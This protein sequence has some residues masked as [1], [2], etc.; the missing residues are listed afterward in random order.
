MCLLLF[1]KSLCSVFNFSQFFV[2]L[3]RYI[4]QIG[5]SFCNLKM[6]S[7]KNDPNRPKS[8]TNGPSAD[9]K[10]RSQFYNYSSYPNYYSAQPPNREQNSNLN[11][12]LAYT[13]SFNEYLHAIGARTH[14]SQGYNPTQTTNRGIP[15]I[16]INSQD[17]RNQQSPETRQETSNAIINIHNS[18]TSYETGN[19]TVDHQ[20]RKEN[21]YLNETNQYLGRRSYNEPSDELPIRHRKKES[22]YM[23]EIKNSNQIPV[24]GNGLSSMSNQQPLFPNQPDFSSTSS[25]NVI[26]LNQQYFNNDATSNTSYDRAYLRSI[27]SNNDYNQQ[28]YYNNT[29]SSRQQIYPFSTPQN[30]ANNYEQQ[31]QTTSQSQNNANDDEDNES[32]YIIKLSNSN[33]EEENQAL[34]FSVEQNQPVSSKELQNSSNDK[35]QFKVPDL[36]SSDNNTKEEDEEEEYYYYDEEIDTPRNNSYNNEMQYN[37]KSQNTKQTQYQQ[38][39]KQTQYQ[40]NPKQTQYQQNTRQTQYQQ[41]QLQQQ[42]KEPKSRFPSIHISESSDDEY[43]SSKSSNF[44]SE[45]NSDVDPSSTSDFFFD[46]DQTLRNRI[47]I[48]QRLCAQSRQISEN[49]SDDQ[50]HQQLNEEEDKKEK[51]KENYPVASFAPQEHEQVSYDIDYDGI[52][53]YVYTGQHNTNENFTFRRLCMR[54]GLTSWNELSRYLPW[55]SRSDL[56]LTLMKMIKKQAISEYSQIRADPTAIG[57][58]NANLKDQNY[59]LKGG[60]WVNKK[61]DK[62]PEEKRATRQK[63]KD[64]YHINTIDAL[65]IDVPFIMSYDYMIERLQSRKVNLILYNQALANE[66]EKR[67][68]ERLPSSG[69]LSQLKFMNNKVCKIH[70]PKIELRS[71]TD[72]SK[73]VF[74]VPEF[75]D[76]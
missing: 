74:D 15:Y 21:N 34:P 70:K 2:N 12:N 10:R 43:Q 44:N 16:S 60:I 39:T 14:A 23:N 63:N 24:L 48:Y 11:R 35:N 38:N 45:D 53:V 41:N 58:E 76:K 59:K 40:Q 46:S 1:S 31:Q 62:T 36:I 64:K 54:Y 67:T 20:K 66:Y 32:D 68:G 27:A 57:S 52:L 73:F 33:S 47:L 19:Q 69:N 28:S 17:Q 65:Q 4:Y 22:D 56:R 7:Q 18:D 55:R 50:N 6:D 25:N 37:K 42:Q 49:Q 26:F 61:W 30:N 29:S 5:K 9:D 75:K 13:G 51:E 72:I 3:E 8:N 71:S